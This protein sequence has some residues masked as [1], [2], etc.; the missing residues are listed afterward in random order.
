MKQALCFSLM[1]FICQVIF[2]DSSTIMLSNGKVVVFENNLPASIKDYYNHE[3][4][5]MNLNKPPEGWI[6]EYPFDFKINLHWDNDNNIIVVILYINSNYMSPYITMRQGLSGIYGQTFNGVYLDISMAYFFLSNILW[7]VKDQ[8][9]E[10]REM[11][12]SIYNF[13]RLNNIQGWLIY[14]NDNHEINIPICLTYEYD[15]GFYDPVAYLQYP[16]IVDNS[17]IYPSNDISKYEYINYWARVKRYPI[18]YINDPI[19]NEKNST[20]SKLIDYFGL[21]IMEG[22]QK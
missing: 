13:L 15:D 11:P 12:N 22:E 18:G 1:L 10:Y 5:T 7:W 3:S 19:T 21:S 6:K 14:Y 8:P 9:A 4:L 20:I 2:A 16:I 17:E